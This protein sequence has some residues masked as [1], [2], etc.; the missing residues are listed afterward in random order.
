[1]TTTETITLYTAQ[2]QIVLDVI[3]RDGVSRVKREYI[4][5][6]YS[7]QAW[8]FAQAYSFFAEHA[9]KYVPRP[10]GAESGIWCFLDWHLAIAGAGCILIELE[11]PRDQV[12]LF[13][14]RVW[15]KM[16]NLNY[17]G[18]DEADEQA[19]EKRITN[20]GLKGPADAFSTAFYPTVKR[21]ILQSW[22]RLFDSAEGCP[23][24]YLQAGLWELRREWIVSTRTPE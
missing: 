8:V 15:N 7:D 1:M 14:S 3:E 24:K 21:E 5:K 18:A 10:E 16:L 13:D 23:E 17:V 6:K 19:F 2:T 12:I 9:P 22:Q 20:M 4:Q 11:V